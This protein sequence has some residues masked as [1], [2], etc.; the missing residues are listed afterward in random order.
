MSE[1]KD[2]KPQA[3]ARWF[4][5]IGFHLLWL[6]FSLG[7][8]GFMLQ[9]WHHSFYRPKPSELHF[10]RGVIQSSFFSNKG[11]GI[12]FRLREGGPW[13]LYE[14]GSPSFYTMAKGCLLQGSPVVAGVVP[15]SSTVW[16]L[17]CCGAFVSDI[18]STARR[19]LETGE[20]SRNIAIL[21]GLVSLYW[22]WRILWATFRKSEPEDLS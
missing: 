13:L 17:T 2:P 8:A 10:Y 20:R 3:F 16:Q 7:M 22:I 9:G 19:H 14:F 18:D 1:A 11:R 21:C 5:R 15:P 4:D 6:L 12:W